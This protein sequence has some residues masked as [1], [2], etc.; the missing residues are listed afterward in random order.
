[1]KVQPAAFL[2]TTLPLDLSGL[3]QLDSGRYHSIWLPDHMVSFWPDS[4]WTPEFTDLAVASP[5]PHRHLDAMAVAAAA[6]VRTQNVPL[7]TSVVDTV[8]RHPALLAQ[9]ALTIDHLSAG[10]FI[11]GLGSGEK[12][13]IEPYGFDF[14]RPV[15]RFEEAL[16]VIRLLWDSEGPVD[17]DGKFFT[18]RHARLDTEPYGGKT[19]PIWIGA[20]GPRSLEIAGRYADGWWPTGAWT[21][22]DYAEK[23]AVVRQSAELAGRDPM[24]ITPCY[25]QVSFM[26]RDEDALAEILQ[27]PLVKSFLLQ[28]SAPV[29]ERF[30]F[31]HPMGPDWRG[32]HDIDP[33]T[34]TRERILDF[35]GR[36]E[37]EMILAVAPH[38]TPQQVA[39]T[40]MDYV[41]AGLRVPKILDYGAMA[42]L[43]Y[44][45]A[46]AEYVR[47]AEDELLTLCGDGR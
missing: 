5:S 27:A 12:E 28:V 17:F 32:F 38:G 31:V 13:N 7:V 35:L 22:E 23:L 43:D 15:S 9:S 33:A 2:R 42:G 16:Q 26:G 14:S 21:P 36:V 39:R 30:G 1:M 44:A 11:L 37:P 4:I 34:L 24:A 18:L 40:V 20:S 41:D 46:S 25:I 6:A 3:D 19:P 10:R 8:R 45:A 29:L 47:A